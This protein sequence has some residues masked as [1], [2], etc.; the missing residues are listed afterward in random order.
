MGHVLFIKGESGNPRGRPLGAVGKVTRE[1]K[2]WARG[3]LSH[4]AY[5]EA[6]Q[7]RLIDG[8]CSPQVEVLLFHYAF[9]KPREPITL[10][11]QYAE[12]QAVDLDKL[13]FNR[14]KQ[15]EQELTAAD[16]DP[17]PSEA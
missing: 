3:L 11:V 13:D 12:A 5:L 17:A 14:L 2:E 10:R 4:P 6:L 7:R 1:V 15:L 16:P 8:T 9:G